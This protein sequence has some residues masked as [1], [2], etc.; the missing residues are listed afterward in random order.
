MVEK[1]PTRQYHEYR[2]SCSNYMMQHFVHMWSCINWCFNVRNYNYDS[3]N[4]MNMFSIC[5]C[6]L[7]TNSTYIAISMYNILISTLNDGIWY[8]F[9]KFLNSLS[10]LYQSGL[11]ECQ[12]CTQQQLEPFWQVHPSQL[13]GEWYSPW[14]GLFTRF[15]M[16][17]WYF[18]TF[19]V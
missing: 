6:G 7:C 15:T 8:L 13:Q 11:W 4:I 14:V 3:F 10:Y 2:T 19:A 1:L 17:N 18:T 12:D 16:L 5:L 9:S